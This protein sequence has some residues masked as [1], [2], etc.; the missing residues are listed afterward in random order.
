M[1]INIQKNMLRMFLVTIPLLLLP[2]C[3]EFSLTSFDTSEENSSQESSEEDLTVSFETTSVYFTYQ[4]LVSQ[5]DIIFTGSVLN[6]SP[7]K[8]NQDSGEYWSE[9]TIEGLTADGEQLTTTHNAWPVY[10]IEMKVTRPFV[11]K[12]GVG[13][14]AVTLVMLGKSPLDDDNLI[15]ESGVRLEADN[16]NIQTGQDL[17]VFG[18]QTELAWR[19]PN[20]PIEL[21][22]QADGTAYFDIGKRTII[23][24]M[25]MPTNA[26]FIK[27]SDGLYHTPND[28]LSK[29]DP[30]SLDDLIQDISQTQQPLIQ[31]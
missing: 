26:Y 3:Q 6:I 5:A 18:L 19:D 12:V 30:L 25:G 7:T 20:R 29:Q 17:L 15:V 27:G 31:Q 22:K 24:L 2:A 23:T 14:E 13:Q 9:T 16:V 8:W 28:A 11:D 21:L 1:N 4:E 10:E